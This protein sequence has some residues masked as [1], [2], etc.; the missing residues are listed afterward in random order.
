[1][2]DRYTS[3]RNTGPSN[4]LVKFLP[5]IVIVIA[6]AIGGFLFFGSRGGKAPAPGTTP[7]TGTTA[8]APQ[9]DAAA[10]PAAPAPELTKEQ[11]V[12]EAGTAFRE[13][14]Y[15]APPGNN[16]LE[17]Y[18]R[19]LDKEPSNQIAKDAL[20]EMFPIVIGPV[21]QSINAGNLDEAT[22]VIDLLA[23]SDPSNYT[24]T[25]LRG[26]LDAKKKQVET[27]QTKQAAVAAAAAAKAAA[28]T[29]AAQNPAAAAATPAPAP[30]PATAAAVSAPAPT[31]AATTPAARPTPAAT[32]PAAPPPATAAATPAPAAGG[33][34]HAAEVLKTVSP[35]YPRE[36]YIKHQEGW[37]EVEFTIT[38]DGQVTGA[39]VAGAQPAR[40]FNEAA[41]RAVQ[42]WT[43]KPKMDNGKAV[44]EHMKRRIE[45]KLGG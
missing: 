15:V 5:I 18:L 33:E 35:E 9:Q 34:S 19:V 1:M 11:L 25:I 12:K 21:E 23:K 24:L 4:P 40:V 14:R 41:L 17:Y 28:A 16:A 32:A 30:A 38:P 31:P 10:A 2:A 20:R 22:R 29:S 42:R 39:A 43:F 3:S 37:V 13:L 45:F 36:A 6:L 8:T 7:V 44:E 27:E 26:K